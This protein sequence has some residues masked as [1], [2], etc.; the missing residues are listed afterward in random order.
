V[1]ILLWHGYLLTG[2]GSNVYTANIAREWRRA[3]HDVLLLCQERHASELDFVDA[4]GDFTKENDRFDAVETGAPGASGRCVVARPAIG[5]VLPVYVYDAYEGF[6]AKRFV[7]LTDEELAAYTDSNVAAMTS[8]ISVHQP[9]AVITGHEVMGPYIALEACRATGTP[10]LAKLHGSALEYAVKLQDR[11]RRYAVEGLGGADVVVGGSRYMVEE[12]SSVIP[13]WTERA[14]VVNP[15]CD[16]ELFRPIERDTAGEALV[17]YVG[18]LI[19]SKGVHNLLAALPL[20]EHP[21][22]TTVVGYGGFEEGLHDLWDALK[23]GDAGRAAGIAQSGETGEPL[24]SLVT[25]L[26]SATPAYFERAAQVD[27]DFPGRLE[28]GPLARVLPTFDVLVVPSVVPEAFGMVAAEA[29]ACGVLPVVPNHSGIAEAG[30]AIEQRLGMPGLLTYD[31]ADPI[32]GIA[33]TVDRVL[34]I[35]PVTRF[36]LGQQASELARER[37]AWS[38][39]AARLLALAPRGDSRAR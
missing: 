39:V 13:G 25:F 2:S 36:E 24:S 22:R 27:V 16:V 8:A 19:A 12:A 10:Y 20:L 21:A 6:T 32:R 26:A 28:H 4:A 34:S 17:G 5:T 3:G 9:D 30:A 7:D 18:K 23:S 1:R 37:W 14:S 15:G 38:E 33:A 29:A 11:Y 35:D 31:A